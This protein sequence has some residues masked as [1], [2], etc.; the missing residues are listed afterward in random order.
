M[1]IKLALQKIFKGILHT[2]EENS[3]KH[4]SFRKNQTYSTQQTSKILRRIKVKEQNKQYQPGN[5]PGKIQ[6]NH[7]KE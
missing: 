7:R 1:S 6:Q 4:E 5:Q 2:E 3:H